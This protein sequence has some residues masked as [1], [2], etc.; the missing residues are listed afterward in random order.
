MSS[1]HF[2]SAPQWFYQLSTYLQIHK[3][4]GSIQPNQARETANTLR[5]HYG[6]C[7]IESAVLS[8]HAVGRGALTAEKENP[9]SE[10][11][12]LS[13]LGAI[14]QRNYSIG[15][16]IWLCPHHTLWERVDMNRWPV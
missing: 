12:L 9:S 5:H 1:K 11:E 14:H 8:L 10:I 7:Q 3:T 6:G 15:Q 16:N 2:S 13:L 4:A